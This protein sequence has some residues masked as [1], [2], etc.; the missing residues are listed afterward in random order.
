MDRK[1]ELKDSVLDKVARYTF[2]RPDAKILETFKNKY[3]K[4][5]YLINIT[6]PEFTCIC[7]V[8]DQPDFATIYISYIPD[9]EC[10]ESKSLK[11]YIYSYRNFGIFYEDCIN[12]ILD[13]CVSICRPRWMRVVGKYYPRGG[14]SFSPAAEYKKEK[15]KVLEHVK[16]MGNIHTS[17]IK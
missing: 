9:R 12:R 6:V 16:N 10:I 5:D 8:T 11:L 2:D 7:P 15:F 3:Q 1:K 17:K 14:I 13:D 4:R